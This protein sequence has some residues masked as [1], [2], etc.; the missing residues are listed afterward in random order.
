MA[1]FG[2]VLQMARYVPAAFL[3]NR[4]FLAKPTDLLF[5][6]YF[7]LGENE[8]RADGKGVRNIFAEGPP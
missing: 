7:G 6:D 5:P 8:R 2:R 1:E 3:K 4:Q